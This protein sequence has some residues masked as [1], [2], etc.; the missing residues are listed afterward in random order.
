MGKTKSSKSSSH[1]LRSLNTRIL[2]K[3]DSRDPIHHL[4]NCLFYSIHLSNVPRVNN[5]SLSG[6]A[7]QLLK[8]LMLSEERNIFNNS[9]KYL[10]DCCNIFKSITREYFNLDE[11]VELLLSYFLDPNI[12]KKMKD[13]NYTN[14]FTSVFNKACNSYISDLP[15]KAP[16]LYVFDDPRIYSDFC[17]DFMRKRLI[18]AFEV[19]VHLMVDSNSEGVPRPLFEE[20]KED[21]DKLARKYKKLK[22]SYKKLKKELEEQ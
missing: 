16:T 7:P 19:T 21:R 2:D 3:K 1:S 18:T 5:S 9:M 10:S 12:I 4:A 20:V 14:L 15:I 6:N 22:K 17:I 8:V 11:Y 13:N